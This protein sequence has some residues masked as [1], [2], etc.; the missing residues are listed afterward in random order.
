MSLNPLPPK[1]PGQLNLDF[2]QWLW[3]LFQNL[4]DSFRTGLGGRLGYLSSLLDRL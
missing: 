4:N 1:A 2:L 3:S